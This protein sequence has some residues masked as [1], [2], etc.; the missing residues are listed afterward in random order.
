MQCWAAAQLAC[1]EVQSEEVVESVVAPGIL[2]LSEPPEPVAS[3]GCIRALVGAGRLVSGHTFVPKVLA[4]DAEQRPGL[5]L[6]RLADP[7]SKVDA[8]RRSRLA[9]S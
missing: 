8:R 4:R 9:R 7:G 6:F 3:F 2:I 1:L 5:V